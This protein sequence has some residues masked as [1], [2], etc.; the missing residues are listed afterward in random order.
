MVQRELDNSTKPVELLI[1]EVHEIGQ[2]LVQ[3]RAFQIKFWPLKGYLVLV[4][5]EECCICIP[6]DLFEIFNIIKK[7]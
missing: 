2:A 6:E 5:G 1:Q 3:N 4:L 7:L